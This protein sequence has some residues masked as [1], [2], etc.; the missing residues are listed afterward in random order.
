MGGDIQIGSSGSTTIKITGIPTAMVPPAT[1]QVT[2]SLSITTTP[3]G[4]TI[5]IDG[6]QQGITPVT[7]ADLAPGGHTMLLKRDGYQDLSA[8]VTINAG[9]TL[10]STVA[11]VPAAGAPDTASPPAPAKSP[12]FGPA[13]VFTIGA[14][15]ALKKLL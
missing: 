6:S 11:M 12:G 2:G 8:P 10:V 3:A 9:Q 7:I 14:I 1:L 4:A 13:L 15:M 5:F